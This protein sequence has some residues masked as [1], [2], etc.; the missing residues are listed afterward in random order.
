ME[1]KWDL[2]LQLVNCLARK[3]NKLNPT[4]AWMR[5]A[6]YAVLSAP[7]PTP[8][9]TPCWNDHNKSQLQ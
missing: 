4:G 8:Y 6:I 9:P 3:P 2:V 7:A 1:Y 5:I